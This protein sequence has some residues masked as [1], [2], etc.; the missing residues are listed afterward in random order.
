MAVVLKHCVWERHGDTLVVLLDPRETIELHDPAGQVGELLG[1]LSSGAFDPSALCS[2]LGAR[3]IALTLTEAMDAIAALDSLGLV[4]D[5]A[6]CSPQGRDQRSRDNLA[7]FGLFSSA[8]V[9]P[10]R[11]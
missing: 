6:G 1:V 11:N 4:E 3:G 2:A 7:F 8:A 5:A 9:S 10:G